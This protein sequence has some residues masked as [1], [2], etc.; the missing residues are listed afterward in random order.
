MNVSDNHFWKGVMGW[1]WITIAICI[2]VSWIARAVIYSDGVKDQLMISC[3]NN[4]R[5][6]GDC[7][8][9]IHGDKSDFEK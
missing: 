8:N 1:M 7:Y 3:V 4:G 9:V 2:F 5:T 6:W